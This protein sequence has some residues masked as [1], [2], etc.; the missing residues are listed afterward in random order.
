MILIDCDALDYGGVED[1]LVTKNIIITIVANE[2]SIAAAP[3]PTLLIMNLMH[4]ITLLLVIARASSQ[5]F[6]SYL[7]VRSTI[8]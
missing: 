7:H 3:F 8:R 2:E 4:L 5:P 1:Y 6:S